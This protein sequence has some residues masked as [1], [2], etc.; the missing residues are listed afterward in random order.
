[1]CLAVNKNLAMGPEIRMTALV[2]SS[3]NFPKQ[4]TDQ[5]RAVN[6]EVLGTVPISGSHI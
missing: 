3:R 4:L 5:T 1:M 6:H 2:K